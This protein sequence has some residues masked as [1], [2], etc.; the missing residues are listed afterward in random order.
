MGFF[1]RRSSE[2]ITEFST[3]LT[4]PVIRASTS[5]LRSSLKKPRGRAR[6]FALSWLRRSRTTPV[7]IGTRKKPPR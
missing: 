3:S 5:P 7:R 6:I 2:L 4:S 1:S